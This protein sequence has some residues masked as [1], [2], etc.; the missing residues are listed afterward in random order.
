MP[1]KLNDFRRD[2][3]SPSLITV[4][5]FD[6]IKPHFFLHE[7]ICLPLPKLH[8]KSVS[9]VPVPSFFEI[10]NITAFILQFLCWRRK[11]YPLVVLLSTGFV[12]TYVPPYPT[13][14]SFQY[15]PLYQ[16]L[17]TSSMLSTPALALH[18]LDSSRKEKIC[19][20]RM[21]TQKK[22]AAQ[23]KTSQSKITQRK[24]CLKVCATLGLATTVVPW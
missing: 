11:Y 5:F 6:I 9:L 8:I 24:S 18:L 19:V 20:R 2:P 17:S 22:K 3:L 21:Y 10:T 15:S 1:P 7:Y 4:I 13:P 14:A 23:R 16:Y 12:S